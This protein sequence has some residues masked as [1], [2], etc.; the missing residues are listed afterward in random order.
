MATLLSPVNHISRELDLKAK[1]LDLR[2]K[3]VV[4]LSNWLTLFMTSVLKDKERP[5]IEPV[6]L[7]NTKC[8]RLGGF[9][10]SPRT[11]G[12]PPSEPRSEDRPRPCFTAA[13]Y[14]AQPNPSSHSPVGR[15]DILTQTQFKKL[16]KMLTASAR[17]TVLKK[18]DKTP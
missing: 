3:V 9:S 18:K 7:G 8:R 12:T 6:I 15:A 13:A 4:T 16:P 14:L 1:N 10:S 2:F 17:I 5:P 11:R